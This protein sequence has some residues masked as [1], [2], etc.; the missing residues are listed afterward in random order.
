MMHNNRTS[1]K[2]KNAPLISPRFLQ[3]TGGIL[4]LLCMPTIFTRIFPQKS[5]EEARS[6]YA[7]RQGIFMEESQRTS[8]SVTRSRLQGSYESPP[9]TTVDP[10]DLEAKRKEY[11][12]ACKD[13]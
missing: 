3:A 10:S 2:K 1:K 13:N 12:K 9:G 5:C 6:E 11:V 4:V 8:D 7:Q